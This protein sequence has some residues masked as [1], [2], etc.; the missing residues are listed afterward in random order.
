MPDN[1]TDTQTD[2]PLRITHAFAFRMETRG[3]E[4]AERTMELAM[5][6]NGD[7]MVVMTTQWPG[8]PV[9]IA[10]RIRLSR[11]GLEALSSLLSNVH[12]IRNYPLRA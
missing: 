12:N 8:E 5:M 7:F 4:D 9:P 2:N 11:P 1:Q 3:P 6:Q 10:T